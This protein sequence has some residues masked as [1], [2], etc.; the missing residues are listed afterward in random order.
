MSQVLLDSSI[1]IPALR[2][3]GGK[4]E[5][6]QV[7]ALL[8]SGRAALTESILFELW[9]GA[10]PGL[11]QDGVRQL[12]RDLPV[13]Q[14]TPAVWEKCFDLARRC[15][16]KGFLIPMGDLLVAACAWEYRVVVEQGDTHFEQIQS[17]LTEAKIL[18]P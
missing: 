8:A 10:K 18:F 16:S 14:T 4:V 17:V 11:E 12:A 1:L 15:R 6:Q 9:R 5:K 2:A 7:T 13:L 3:G